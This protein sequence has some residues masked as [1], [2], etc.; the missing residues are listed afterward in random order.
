[1]LQGFDQ[2]SLNQQQI[3]PVSENKLKCTYVYNFFFVI[4]QIWFQLRWIS[5]I[6][7]IS[8]SFYYLNCFS[9]S[10]TT[11]LFSVTAPSYILSYLH[12][13]SK[14][15]QWVHYEIPKY[16]KNHS[17][18]HG[19]FNDSCWLLIPAE[20]FRWLH[21]WMLGIFVCVINLNT[22]PLFI[23]RL[24]IESSSAGGHLFCVIQ[25]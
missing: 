13:C 17:K 15:L 14:S 19:L 2:I 21:R 20:H 1:M 12:C 16:P 5:L 25:I 7:R 3:E 24:D 9:F 23:S 11:K 10:P 6:G 8:T 18:L 22:L 4:N